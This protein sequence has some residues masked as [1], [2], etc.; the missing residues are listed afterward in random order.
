MTLRLYIARGTEH[1]ARALEN[2]RRALEQVSLDMS[3]VEVI[4]VFDEPE[5]ALDDGVIVT[6]M[7]VRP[8]SARRMAG[9]LDNVQ[10]LLDMVA[11]D[12]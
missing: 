6:P 7:L 3:V 8:G 2:V 10:A 9:T 11:A 1:S 5:R 4:D 12:E